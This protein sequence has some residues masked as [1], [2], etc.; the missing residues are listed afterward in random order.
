MSPVPI[1]YYSDVL[2]IWAYVAEARVAELTNVFGHD[3][4][5]R[6]RFVSVFGD[7]R[8]KI[9]AA[10]R[11]HGGAEGYN[12][13][14]LAIARRFP[15]VKV[16]PRVWIDPQPA[17]S[18]SP[19]LF[20]AAL[21]AQA[22]KAP[23]DTATA[24]H[25]AFESTLWAFRRGFFEDGLDIS[26]WDVQRDLAKPYGVDTDAVAAFIADGSAFARLSADYQDA[27]KAR[28][29]GSPTFVLNEGRQKLYGN[30]GFR[31]LEA[32]VREI[33]REPTGDQASW[34]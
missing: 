27:D 10:W 23:P 30:L 26:Q 19:H 4:A 15:H 21:Q 28:I 6:H 8:T 18:A 25:A 34:C 14:V 3:I 5:I 29:E 1:T 24:A 2:C 16:N 9:D 33:M 22:S 11:D 17:S 7:A 32:N 20:L 31:I 13:H 12:R